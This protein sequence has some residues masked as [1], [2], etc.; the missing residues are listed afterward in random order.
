[1]KPELFCA[2]LTALFGLLQEEKIKPLIAQRFPLA[3]A[4]DAQ[5]LP[6][7]G[8]VIGKIVPARNAIA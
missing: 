2:D 6:G 3:E 8:G 1:M 7:K 5:E 4:R